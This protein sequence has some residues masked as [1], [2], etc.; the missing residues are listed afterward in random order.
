MFVPAVSRDERLQE[1]WW[2]LLS[3]HV[4]AGRHEQTLATLEG[5][6]WSRVHLW[7]GDERC[8]PE[9]DKDSNQRTAHEALISKVAIPAANVHRVRTELTPAECAAEYEGEIVRVVGG[10]GRERLPRGRKPA[11][12]GGVPAIDV[13][14][15][16]IG[17]DGHTLS[18]F[19]G[20]P[21]LWC[22]SYPRRAGL[23]HGTRDYRERR[24]RIPRLEFA[25]SIYPS[26][27]SRDI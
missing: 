27:E 2:T 21:S 18:L 6:D 1:A 8:V 9:T 11:A 7:W 23:R 22:T 25:R 15:L 16:G 5:I 12:L 3:L 19:P 17:T 24:P 13:L 14:L 20:S 4:R 10:E 26:F